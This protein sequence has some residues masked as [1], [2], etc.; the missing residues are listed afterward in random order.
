MFG[1]Q[2]LPERFWSKVQI[3]EA[4]CSFRY[5]ERVAQKGRRR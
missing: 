3:D 1:D 2:R 4:G 5:V